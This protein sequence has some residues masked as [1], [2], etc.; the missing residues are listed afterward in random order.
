MGTEL[1]YHG[2]VSK[3]LKM[4]F[5]NFVNLYEKL[6]F[7]SSPARKFD[8]D[9]LLDNDIVKNLFNINGLTGKGVGIN[10]ASITW[11]SLARYKCSSRF[12]SHLWWQFSEPPRRRAKAKHC[13]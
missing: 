1:P 7:N 10:C 12:W 4:R 5:P 11:K 9:Q 2:A 8:D 3:F 13:H 6:T